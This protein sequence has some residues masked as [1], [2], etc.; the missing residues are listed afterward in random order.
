MTFSPDEDAAILGFL[1][2]EAKKADAPLN[3][4]RVWRKFKIHSGSKRSVESI[5]ARFR[6]YLRGSIHEASQFD[7]ETKVRMLFA[8]ETPVD[9]QYLEKLRRRAE[10]K[11]NRNGAI[12]RYKS[13][14]FELSG[15]KKLGYYCSEDS[16]S[17]GED[18]SNVFFSKREDLDILNFLAKKA[19]LS[20][21]SHAPMSSIW[22]EFVVL[23]GSRRAEPCITRR[24]REHLAPEIH[25]MDQFD[26]DTKIRMLFLSRTPINPCFLDELRESAIVEVDNERRILKFANDRIKLS[27]T[28]PENGSHD[29][30]G[31]SERKRKRPVKLDNE[32]VDDYG[33]VTIEKQMSRR[34]K[35]ED[36]RITT[37]LRSYKTFGEEEEKRMLQFVAEKA[38]T[39]GVALSQRHLWQEF[40]CETGSE[41]SPESL[42]MRFFRYLAPNIHKMDEY[43]EVGVQGF[44]GDS[45]LE[46]A[47]TRINE[48]ECKPE[49]AVKPKPVENDISMNFQ[50]PEDMKEAVLA[51]YCA[52]FERN[53]EAVKGKQ[54]E[55]FMLEEKDDFELEEPKNKP[56][57]ED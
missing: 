3:M 37:G 29:I 50:V 48:I 28:E 2:R 46:C 35:L 8:S 11:V 45:L 20:T 36:K 39:T 43:P 13:E 53:E 55:G 54:S 32:I 41:R 25:K 10:V 34:Q 52:L 7:T 47:L 38:K 57:W 22:Q 21:S 4:M 26:V 49:G 33:N 23:T 24:F 15:V 42:R 18:V 14:R 31:R 12:V 17:Q 30:V 27:A 51:Q 19:T 16:D 9:R 1:A 40:R 56:I 5:L 44:Y 6:T